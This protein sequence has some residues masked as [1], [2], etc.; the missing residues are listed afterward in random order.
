MALLSSPNTTPPD[1]YRYVQAETQSRFTALNHVDL[2]N[3]VIAHRQHKCL[4]PTDFDSVWK[5]IQRQICEGMFPGICYGENGET[6]R[7]LVD[8]SREI[9]VNPEKLISLAE[10]A[11]KFIA[12]GG[13]IV[14]KAESERRAA[15]C[16]GCQFN[17]VSTCLTCTPVLKLIGA[18]IPSARKEPG[19]SACGI[20]GC[21]LEALVLLPL[22]TLENGSGLQ[23]PSYCWKNPQPDGQ[24][25]K[26][27]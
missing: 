17:R 1:G 10:A 7:P 8:Q 9:A 5:E 16:R 4:A 24:E 12:S 3:M 6:Y 23:Y 15:I 22:G 26:A 19:L 11:V 18:M 25:T 14:P 13:E 21:S 2:T 20:C 27:T